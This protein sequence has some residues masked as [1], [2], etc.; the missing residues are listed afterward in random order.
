MYANASSLCG[1]YCYEAIGGEEKRCAHCPLSKESN[2]SAVIYNAIRNEWVR[3]TAASAEWPNAGACSVIIAKSIEKESKSSFFDAAG[4]ADYDELLELDYKNDRYRVV[5]YR[6]RENAKGNTEGSISEAVVSLADKMIHPDDK[7]RFYDFWL[8]DRLGEESV[9]AEALV[10]RHGE[11][12]RKRPD[13]SYG[14][15]Q[16][17][18]APARQSTKNSVFV[19]NYY[20]NID[21][22]DQSV[23]SLLL[24]NNF[25]VN[26]LLS[27]PE[28]F[29]SVKEAL[30]S[31]KTDKR[32]CIVSVDIE[33][34]K[35]LNEW[36]GRSAGDK[37]LAGISGLVKKMC[38]AELGIGGYFGNDDFAAFI[39][40]DK[41][42]IRKLY[43]D[44]VALLDTYSNK[45][46]FLPAFGIYE[47]KSD[48][49]RPF[50]MYDRAELARVSV[51]GSYTE[52]IKK[53]DRKMLEKLES[54]Y[55]LFSDVQRAFKNN[56]FTFYL[57][58]KCNMKT[59]R[60]IGAEALVRWI[61]EEKGVISPGVFI[62]FLENTGFIAELDRYIWEEVCRWQRKRLDQGKN[63]VPVSVNASK[64]DFYSM[65]VSACFTEL[66]KKYNLEPSMLDIEITESTYT[67]ENSYVNKAV[68]KLKKAG[69][70][71]LMDDFGSGY[72]S[73]NMLKDIEVDVLKL[74]MRFLGINE[75]NEAKGKGIV[76]TV[77]KMARL[78]GIE[79]IVEGVE[80]EEQKTFLLEMGCGYGQGYY[81]YPPLA[82]ADFE[83][84][85]ENADNIDYEGFRENVIEQ[86]RLKDLLGEDMFSEIMIN[87]MLGAV[88]FYDFHNGKLTL[89]RYN[90]N[91]SMLLGDSQFKSETDLRFAQHFYPEDKKNIF[92]MFEDAK[93]DIHRG[94]EADICRRRPDG[95]DMWLH[96]RTFYLNEQNGHD[97]YYSSVSDVTDTYRKNEML[98]HQNAALHFLNNDMP[99]GYY[100]HQYNTDC[101]FMHISRRFLDIFGY[102]REEIKER[103]DDKF[104]NM[105]HPD[106][107][108]VVKKSMSEL[109][110]NAGN[111][112]KSYRM[113]SKNG[114]IFITDQGRLVKYKNREFLQGVVLCDIDYYQ[115]IS[116]RARN[117][118]SSQEKTKQG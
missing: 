51:K 36:Y 82:T 61:S 98:T 8:I 50:T 14:W 31:N 108:E 63:V 118:S 99:G 97:I 43:S 9:P 57:Q 83:K 87:N 90:E 67:E 110:Q 4:K 3:V 68:T 116:D 102:T 55:I 20:N 66:I 62:P 78:M 6:N 33:N 54:E 37:L 71:V 5:Y 92:K 115:A 49:K 70:H 10:T 111:Y 105:V 15:V 74:D 86:L 16:Q 1:R 30:Q 32:L 24:G 109:E 76:E 39:E 18:L 69:F 114:Y 107:R 103:F 44:I 73:L 26:G 100:R 35:L 84:I 95:K 53:F 48:K 28:F 60:I 89:K 27:K 7:A 38:D 93:R 113:L 59:G 45:T 79:I 58:P 21:S 47:I 41:E 75:S 112:S 85:I 11:F 52:R 46:G 72:S 56:E 13:G 106:D 104:I 29:R 117:E 12:R 42:K 64:I 34:F 17:V 81:F 23:K 101:D 25:D 88:A 77:R 96:L 94:A 91:Y 22:Q 19:I 40:Y 65:D 2:G 80:T